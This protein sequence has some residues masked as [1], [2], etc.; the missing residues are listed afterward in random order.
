M[1]VDNLIA[2]CE[3]NDL[4]KV[5]IIIK[6][7]TSLNNENYLG[8]TPLSIA[9]DKGFFELAKMLIANGADVN[10]KLCNGPD[11]Q[12]KP[13]A[14]FYA[15]KRGFVEITELL[16]LNGAEINVKSFYGFT[17]IESAIYNGSVEIVEL[18][19]SNGANLKIV[20]DKG[21]ISSAINNKS[22]KLIKL[23]VSN[24]AD[25]NGKDIDGNTPLHYAVKSE[26]IEIIK[27]LLSNGANVNLENKYN[28]T[29]IEFAVKKG[30]KEI[31][32]LLISVGCD[33]NSIEE[34]KTFLSLALEHGKIDIFKFL[35]SKGAKIDL[36][37]DHDKSLIL[38][39]IKTGSLELIDLII[40]TGADINQGFER[41]D[42]TPLTYAVKNSTIEVLDYLISH[43]S[44]V[45]KMTH[46]G[47]S[48][49][50][51]ALESCSY[52]K[53]ELLILHG[54][55]L[56]TIDNSGK[57]CLHIASENSS[58]ENVQLLLSKGFEIDAKTK[59]I[60]EAEWEWNIPTNFFLKYL[61]YILKP[62]FKI[63][64]N[65]LSIGSITPL[66]LAVRAGH[67][68]IVKFLISQGANVNQRDDEGNTPLHYS[69]YV[70][71]E[72]EESSK[73][74]KEQIIRIL[75]ECG[76]KADVA[77]NYL[78]YPDCFFIEKGDL[79]EIGQLLR[80]AIP[81][82]LLKCD[83]SNG[84]SKFNKL[85][86]RY[87]KLY[88]DCLVYD[89]SS[90]ETGRTSKYTTGDYIYS[91]N[92]AL[93][94][95]DGIAKLRNPIAINMLYLLTTIRDIQVS[96]GWICDNPGSKGTLSYAPVREKA[97]NILKKRGYPPVN[98]D[99]FLDMRAYKWHRNVIARI[100]HI[101]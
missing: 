58:L 25:I 67:I 75:L 39:A 80:I 83:Y 54:A 35:I 87:F 22:L 4:D 61:F 42:C 59:C 93:K 56:D 52:E 97:K 37:V 46:S 16:I 91:F 7:G 60:E 72:D 96:L 85:V 98:P 76:A 31:T 2:A 51:I 94:A 64:V 44:E 43:G 48:A 90:K 41:S 47:K 6:N 17:P 10:Q 71:L 92:S 73:R 24:G 89:V 65:K 49:L 8:K 66:H 36:A 23:L 100:F 86:N 38:Y 78:V 82:K 33:I 50:Q 20:D 1:E 45:N 12:Q 99:A 13:N 74:N 11:H 5:T 95:I 14:L 84:S 32:E 79:R 88:N 30:S 18:L 3:K 57:Y 21:I 63:P 28:L 69:R 15:V 81:E 40:S 77:N 9:A 55:A 62:F 101:F 26:N 29:P 68:E 70:W 34:N 19:I 53:V 27:F